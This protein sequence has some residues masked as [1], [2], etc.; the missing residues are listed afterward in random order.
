MVLNLAPNDN[1]CFP[2]TT[3]GASGG[4]STDI[5]NLCIVPNVSL[6]FGNR[7]DGI[8]RHSSSLPLP[9]F[10]VFL[11]KIVLNAHGPCMKLW[12]FLNMLLYDFA[13]GSGHEGVAV[14]L[15]GLYWIMILPI[16]ALIE[17]LWCL[18]SGNYKET[19]VKVEPSLWCMFNS[20]FGK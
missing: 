17:A 8:W 4:C 14:L 12:Q 15:L 7:Q 13:Y 10:V 2:G 3:V 9:L 1:V 6:G 16:E 11:Q 20:S 5:A 18:V 19:G